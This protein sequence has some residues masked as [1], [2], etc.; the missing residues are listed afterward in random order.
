MAGSLR[1]LVEL[2]QNI[3]LLLALTFLYGFFT[4]KMPRFPQKWDSVLLGGMFGIAAL[5][6]MMTPINI[7]SGVIIDGRVIMVGLASVFGG[8]IAA[9]MASF[10][11]CVYRAYLGGVGVAP[12]IGAIITAVMIGCFAHHF[13]LKRN[14]RLTPSKLFLLGLCFAFGGMLWAFALPQEMAWPAF[15]SYA[16][17]VFIWYPL[18]TFLL[19]TLFLK[20][21]DRIKAEKE[22][23]ESDRIKTDFINTVAHEFRTPLTSIQGFSELLLTNKSLPPVEQ[24]ECLEYIYKSSEDL[25]DLVSD[26]LDIARIEAG[27]GLSLTFEKN[28]VSEVLRQVEPLLKAQSSSRYFE[29]SLASEETLL[30]VDKV[31]VGHVLQNLISNAVKFSEKKTLIQITGAIVGN[32]YRISVV[33]QGRG[34]SHEQVAKV[35]NKFY[36]VDVSDTAVE[37]VGLGMNIVKHIV[38][39]HGGKIWVESELDKGTSVNFTLPLA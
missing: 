39:T 7:T 2:G 10:P 23:Q 6:G 26:M 13:L 29:I 33:D 28:T 32:K 4:Q 16:F 18:G 15:K 24:K 9:L 17:P 1:V 31:K 21:K 34:M 12:G 20:E 35:F 37:G 25:A 22:L 36:R 27:M 30:E 14:L 3:A 11:V 5:V 38:E 8:P 19:G